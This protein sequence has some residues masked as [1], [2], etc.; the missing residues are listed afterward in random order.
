[1]WALRYTIKGSARKGIHMIYDL[2]KASMWKR[3]SAF[4]FDAIILCIVAV[5]FAWL[6]SV[7]LG[8]DGYNTAL[9]EA[10]ERYGEEYGI[11]LRMGYHE[12]EVLS[13]EETERLNA[14]MDALAADEGAN[15][16]Y[17]MLIQLTLVITSL[18]ILLAF[19]VMEFTIPMVLGNGQTLGK[20]IFGLGLM[21]TDGVRVNGRTL[22]IRTILGKYAIETMVPVLIVFMIFFGMVGLI[23]TLVL[24]GLAAVQVIMVIATRTNA[25]LH[26]ALATTVAVDLASQMIFNDRAAMIAYKEKAHREKVAQQA[27]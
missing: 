14:A 12:Y 1:M 16:A 3:I 4:L 18:G 23:G 5:L 20:K 13:P 2:Q 15:Y 9:T 7:A 6:L 25:L 17:N 26:D 21:H 11:D 24:L 19:V 22:F 10:Y 8:Y 27:L